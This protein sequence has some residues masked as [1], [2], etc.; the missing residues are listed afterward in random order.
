M[1]WNVHKELRIPVSEK[2]GQDH[3]FR[4]RIHSGDNRVNGAVDDWRHIRHTRPLLFQASSKYFIL[5][6]PWKMV[7]HVMCFPC[8]LR[9][10]C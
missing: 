4:E 1:K 5:M 3:F 6:R 8:K 7:G 10:T 9:A 2:S